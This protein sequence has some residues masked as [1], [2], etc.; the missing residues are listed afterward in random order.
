M[1]QTKL[2]RPGEFLLRPTDGHLRQFALKE[3]AEEHIVPEFRKFSEW[4]WYPLPVLNEEVNKA[5]DKYHNFRRHI[6]CNIQFHTFF[7]HFEDESAV[8]SWVVERAS[9]ELDLGRGDIA[10]CPF[11]TSAMGN[12]V[13]QTLGV[14]DD[15]WVPGWWAKR[16]VKF[17]AEGIVEI[18]CSSVGS[19]PSYWK[20]LLGVG[21][22][23][24]FPR[25]MAETLFPFHQPVPV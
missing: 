18:G 14:G 11:P 8:F 4:E 3:G 7:P 25:D 23:K 1:L 10:Y 24:Y 5:Y 13:R 17:A 20:R 6:G 16:V 2:L 9:G 19:S 15:L 21:D 22:R 12:H